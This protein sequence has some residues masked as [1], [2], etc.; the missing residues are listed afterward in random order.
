MKLNRKGT[1]VVV[2]FKY[3]LFNYFGY[4]LRAGVPIGYLAIR[5]NLFNFKSATS[6]TSWGI[7]AIIIILTTMSDKIKEVI[8]DYNTYLGNTAKY[9]KYAIVST[10]AFTISLVAYISIGLLVW[11]LGFI[12]LGG[13]ASIVPFS[14]YATESDKAKRM[15]E[16]LKKENS[17]NELLQLKALKQ[18]KA[19]NR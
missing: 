9:S 7:I 10:T 8:H 18:Q 6:V 1:R 12:A 3:K 19:T 17:E 4:I 13:V 11:V 5:Y 14:I 2:D 16:Q 15:T